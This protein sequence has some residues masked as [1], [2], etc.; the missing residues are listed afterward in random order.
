[1]NLRPPFV[2]CLLA[3]ALLGAAADAGASCGSAVC[4]IN[5]DWQALG[6]GVQRG[7]R[8]KVQYEFIDQDRLRE[9]SDDVSHAEP[10]AEHEEV[11]TVN[12]NWL[13]TA[14]Y[15]IDGHWGIN[16]TAPFLNRDHEH[17]HDPFDE[18][19]R[20]T[21]HFSDL[22]DL[23]L[24]GRYQVRGGAEGQL[25][26]WATFGVK[27]PT[28]RFHVANDE[29]EEAERTLQPGTGTTDLLVGGYV[30]LRLPP[31]WGSVFGGVSFQTPLNERNGFRPGTQ[32]QANGGWNYPVTRHLGA[33]LQADLTYR[34]R[35]RGPDAEPDDSGLTT[36]SVSPGVSLS[37]G[38]AT[39]LYTFVQ[40]PAYR[41]VNG[42]QLTYHAAWVAGV[43]VSF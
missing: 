36:L 27:L 14:D 17:I 5:T 34:T 13:A 4:S 8:L 43:S 39:R 28:G 30:Q 7:W 29:G 40:L 11:R 22:G 26:T 6:L 19:E 21:W 41:H 12:R 3:L 16:L 38:R 9:G 23:R 37:V 20:E 42:V 24:Q 18:A 2:P 25:L 33:I 15:G 1:M 31:N 32:Y 35:D 10:D